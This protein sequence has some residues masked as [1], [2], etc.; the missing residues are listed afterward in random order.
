M[1]FFARML[2]LNDSRW[3]T[4]LGGYRAP[5]DPRPSLAKLESGKE[6]DS[7]WHE[8]WE[9]LH[10][11]RDVGEASYAAVPHLV[12]IYRKNRTP[13]WNI[14]AMVSV[15]ELARTEG[16]NPKVPVWLEEAYFH[17]IQEI[18]EIGIGELHRVQDR[19]IV[20]A[21]LGVIAIAK[22]LRAH[23][24]FLSLYSEDEM[25]DIESRI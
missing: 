15:I 19:E 4:L 10:H 16:T 9:E 3:L 25:L 21:I 24:R 23:G 18:A 20:S 2:D 22:G 12:R 14:Y 11:Q 13:E 7:A 1:L 17:A 6:V 5:F 8:L